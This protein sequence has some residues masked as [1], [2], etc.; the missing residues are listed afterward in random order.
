[1]TGSLLS[2]VMVVGVRPAISPS[3]T[4]NESTKR[5]SGAVEGAVRLAHQRAL[6]LGEGTLVVACAVVVNE[7]RDDAG[8]GFWD[9]AAQRLA[10]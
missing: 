4:E 6:E 2:V 3:V 9:S 8:L 10:S 1:M 5:S 7:Q